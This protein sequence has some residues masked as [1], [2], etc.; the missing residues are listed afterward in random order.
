[1]KKQKIL[2]DA[3]N[4]KSGGGLVHLKAILNSEIFIKSKIEFHIIANNQTLKLLN[5][6]YIKK[7]SWFFEHSFILTFLWKLFYFKKYIK[8]IISI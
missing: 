7:N 8:K 4:I 1:M 5:Q 2:I 3:T 6:K